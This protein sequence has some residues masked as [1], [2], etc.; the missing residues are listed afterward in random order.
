MNRTSSHQFDAEQKDEHNSSDRHRLET[1]LVVLESDR[2][3]LS[4]DL[5][6][7]E[8]ERV[9]S[10]RKIEREQVQFQELEDRRAKIMK[11]IEVLDEEL[12]HVKRKFKSL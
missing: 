1:S 3:R 11:E 2:A 9:L 4:R 10:R 5:A 8:S 7:L 12:R 6:A